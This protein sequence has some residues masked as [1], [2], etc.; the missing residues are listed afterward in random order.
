MESNTPRISM[1]TQDNYQEKL[2]ILEATK[3]LPVTKWKASHVLT[4]LEIEMSMPMYGAKCAENVKSGKVL[5]G[6]SDAELDSAL[7][8]TSS[9]HRRKLRL[10]IEEYRD[11]SSV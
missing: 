3:T 1:L 11:P 6:L 5:L 7:G 10:A 9:I 2:Q 4:W 8:L